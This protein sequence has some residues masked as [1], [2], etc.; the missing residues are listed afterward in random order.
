MAAAQ[1]LP[2]SMEQEIKDSFSIEAWQNQSFDHLSLCR[3]FYHRIILVKAGKGTLQIDEATY[4]VNN[5]EL[6]LLSRGQVYQFL[7]GTQ[8]TGY[9]LSFGDCFWEKAPASASNC[10]SVLFNNTAANQHLAIQHND[11]HELST[12]F[13]SL[14]Q[15]FEKEDYINKPDAL[16]AFLK[17]IMIKIANLHAAL[18]KG[19][20]SYDR[21]LYRQFI[22]L[23]SQ[24]YQTTHEVAA[25]ADLLG[26]STRKLADLCRQC[27]GKGAKEIINGQLI[28][29]AKR[30][31]QFSSRPVK[32]I[33]FQLNFSTPEQF[34][35]F[36]KKNAGR[37]PHEYRAQFVKIG[38]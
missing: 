21:Q 32:E 36:F 7:P 24:Q 22:E 27:S 13:E 20:D 33:A 38:M 28:A 3:L 23:V 1:F 2:A 11:Y 12:F 25:F 17:I 18:A 16:A 29:E 31:L 19:Y 26:I 9:T 6:F 14:R 37:S 34:S 4:P 5:N 10:K 15:E 35:H 30:A 8:V